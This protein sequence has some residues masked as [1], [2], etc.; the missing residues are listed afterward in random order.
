MGACVF[1]VSRVDF[2][3]GSSTQGPFK[4]ILFEMTPF[5]VTP[6]K[7]SFEVTFCST[8]SSICAHVG[9]QSSQH[10]HH[11]PFTK[12]L[13]PKQALVPKRP[14]SAPHSRGRSVSG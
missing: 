14:V 12:P 1:C 2:E 3:M 8:Q 7:V 13:V 5:K 4:V 6:F 11:T 10:A 9:H